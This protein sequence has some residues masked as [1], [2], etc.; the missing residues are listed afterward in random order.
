MLIVEDERADREIYK[1]FLQESPAFAFEFAE[2]DSAARGI[3]LASKWAP[4]CILLDF[5]LPDMNGLEALDRLRD[6]NGRLPCAVVMLT[7]FGGEDLAVTVLK[8]GAMDYLPKGHLV[9]DVLARSVTNAIERFQM[10]QRIDEQRAALERNSARYQTL[11]EA[12]P[13]MVWVSNAAGRIEFANCQW[14]TYAG[15][16]LYQGGPFGW[17]HLLY[18]EDRERSL[19][20][21]NKA[22]H[23]GSPLEVEQRLKRAADGNYRWHL[24]RAVPFRGTGGEITNWFGTCTEI[25]N[26]KRAETVNLQTEKQQGIGRLAAGVAHDF[27]N[28]LAI[29]LG[30]TS[31]AMDALGTTHPAHEMLHRAVRAA[32]RAA[33]LTDK[34]LAYAGKGNLCLEQ[35]DVNQLVR[36]TCDALRALIPKTIRL[37]FRPGPDLPCLATDTRRLRQVILELL[38]NAAE[39]IREG[40]VGTIFVRTQAVELGEESRSTIPAGK[41]VVL[42]VQDSGCGMDEETQKRIFDP[43]FTTKFLGRGL[44]LAAVEGFVRSNGG[45]VRVESKPGKGARF[46]ILLRAIAV[47][48]GWDHART[49]PIIGRLA[50]NGTSAF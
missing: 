29:I 40:A 10:Q 42:E 19:A 1:R 16:G 31:L 33:E 30:G 39:A 44:G 46:Q 17:D 5:Q 32:E 48:N 4:D 3:E 15:L 11:L 34:M 49:R 38:R 7:A 45:D 6:E 35:T 43:F 27:N 23:A 36:E 21:W 2:S 25:E 8:C 22:W 37:H 47:D 9:G 13:H 26:Q 24:T 12:I 14:L 28:Q 50:H 18:P 20:A 41:Y